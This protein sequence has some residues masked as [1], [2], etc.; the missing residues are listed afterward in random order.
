MAFD[1]ITAAIDA[2]KFLATPVINHFTEKQERQKAKLESDLKINQAKTKA[3]IEK[4]AM[5]QAADIAWENTSI[6]RSGWKDE[7][8]TLILSIPMIMCFIPGLVD[9]VRMGF[10]AL[11]NTPA[12]YRWA[13]GIA[14]GSAFGVRKFADVMNLKKGE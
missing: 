11:E 3:N 13:V 10:G 4:I 7:Y 12:W 2:V 9:Y 5:G 8:W 6:D 1:P 14:I